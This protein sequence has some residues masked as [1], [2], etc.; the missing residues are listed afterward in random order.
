MLQIFL[1]RHFSPGRLQRPAN[2]HDFDR[3]R[4]VVRAAVIRG[5]ARRDVGDIRLRG[6]KRHVLLAQGDQVLAGF[7]D[8]LIS[9][10]L[11]AVDGEMLTPKAIRVGQISAGYDII[12]HSA[13]INMITNIITRYRLLRRRW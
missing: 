6:L 5:A 3:E 7:L 2:I 8:D 9:F 10:R 4:A 11:N 12:Q 13:R 1:R